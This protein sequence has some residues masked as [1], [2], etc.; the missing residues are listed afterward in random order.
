[1]NNKYIFYHLPKTGGQS[2]K[3]CLREHLNEHEEFIN[4]CEV[5]FEAE[6]NL[7]LISWELREQA[8]RDKAII[9]MGHKVTKDTHKLFS[10]KFH[11]RHMVVFREPAKLIVS[12]YNYTFRFVESPPN[13]WFWHFKLLLKGH[14]NW[15][16]TNFFRHFLRKNYVF[17]YFL[18]DYAFFKNIM[19]S[20]W[21]V[22]AIENINHDFN[23]IMMF[24]GIKDV[25]L[26]KTNISKNSQKTKKHLVLTPTLR[27]KLNNIHSMDIKLYEY[28]LKRD[29][30][31]I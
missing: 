31:S 27:T 5:G 10:P 17:S 16:A 13:F 6:I 2:V 14:R 7:N 9:V 30:P 22:G 3:D 26:G 1:M 18:P 24:F 20:F 4:Y 15:Q 12:L 19:D 23:K 28:S 11:T 8:K 21:Y 29:C 25:S